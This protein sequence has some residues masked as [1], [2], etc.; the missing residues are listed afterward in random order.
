[1]YDETA[2]KNNEISP[3]VHAEA[4]QET[5]EKGN[6]T[7]EGCS[8]SIFRGK[9]ERLPGPKKSKGQDIGDLLLFFRHEF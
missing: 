1:M 4:Y 2:N 3:N 6:G 5:F 8:C 7:E 9:K